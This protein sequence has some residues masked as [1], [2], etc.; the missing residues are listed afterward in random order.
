ML[1][2][3]KDKNISL[4][5]VREGKKSSRKFSLINKSLAPA[6]LLI[7]F[8][9]QLPVSGV[10]LAQPN[11]HPIDLSRDH[12][13][14]NVITITPSKSF[15]IKPNEIKTIDVEYSPTKRTSTFSETICMQFQEK[16]EPISMITGCCIGAEFML[17]REYISFGAVVATC[18]STLKV[19]LI[20][21]GDMG[22]K[23]EWG[24][25]DDVFSISPAFGYCSAGSEVT[26]EVTFKPKLI[27][28]CIEKVVSFNFS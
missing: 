16:S 28:P 27:S 5:A 24:I 10:F 17:N 6:S 20:N 7:G 1:L 26:I 25:D 23:F 12:R 2:E 13:L 4:G 19:K 8:N 18:T 11:N 14:S 15:V 3:A 9:D 21:S 22:G